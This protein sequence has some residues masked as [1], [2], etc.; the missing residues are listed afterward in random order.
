MFKIG[1]MRMKQVSL[2]SGG[3]H[4]A[5]SVVQF[6]RQI[7]EGRSLGLH[8]VCLAHFQ[9]NPE[10]LAKDHSSFLGGAWIGFSPLFP[11]LVYLQLTYLPP[12]KRE[13]K[14]SHVSFVLLFYTTLDK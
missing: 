7:L 12:S 6:L 13:I 9:H 2:P 5:S 3:F 4:L 11:Y 14:T 8:A 1:L 10:L